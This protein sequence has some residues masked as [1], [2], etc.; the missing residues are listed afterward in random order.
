[1]S[2]IEAEHHTLRDA[3]PLTVRTAAAHDAP[4]TLDLF[5]SVLKEGSY[6]VQTP[7]EVTLTDDDERGS[8]E[9]AR[10][11]PGRLFLVAVVDGEVVGMVRAGAGTNQRTRHFADVDSLWVRASFRRRGVAGLLLSALVSWAREHPEIEKLGLFVFS[12]N[13]AAIHL[14]GRYGFAIEGRY[15]RD[16]KFEDGTY[17]DT[18]AMGLLVKERISGPPA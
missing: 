10:G 3:T 16:I 12:T 18:V 15:P 8:I 11:G 2:G 6:T 9:A 5:R 14:Y 17:A 13:A 4:G 1:M 7:S